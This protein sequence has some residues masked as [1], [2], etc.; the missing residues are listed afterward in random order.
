MEFFL[1]RVAENR[2]Y[3]NTGFIEVILAQKS[4]EVG[5]EAL[6]SNDFSLTDINQ[7]IPG[8]SEGMRGDGITKKCRVLSPLGTGTNYGMSYIP[9]V[10]SLG[11]VA[12]LESNNVKNWTS[13]DGFIWLGGIYGGKTRGKDITLPGDDTDSFNLN[14]EDNEY[15]SYISKS[16]VEDGILDSPYLTE[17][18]F[19]VKLKTSKT[20][21]IKDSTT[22]DVAEKHIHYDTNVCTNELSLRNTRN[23]LR[24]NAYDTNDNRTNIS[25]LT[26]QKDMV[27]LCRITN[28]DHNDDEREEQ[29]QLFDTEKIQ[30]KF[31]N[32]K[33]NVD[34]VLQFDSSQA[35]LYF[36]DPD[37]KKKFS[38]QYDNDAE[39]TTI[40]Q[41]N[42]DKSF[43]RELSF[44]NDNTVLKAD[45]SGKKVT[46]TLDNEG[47]CQIDAT[48]DVTIH[49]GENTTINADKNCTITAKSDCSVTA[50]N[51][52]ISGSQVTLTGGAL[53]A[54]GASNTDTSGPFCAIKVCPITGI[55]HCG[56]SVS[57]T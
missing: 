44:T 5:L 31:I 39:T 35:N 56:S 36:D 55:P 13:D 43:V 3:G 41:S 48:K 54:T 24:F 28:A 16:N 33:T 7:F 47:N 27:Q 49:S 10:N 52:T 2:F 15:I 25:D 8:Y 51:I 14:H 26:M 19:L 1:G 20:N 9:Q 42:T 46:I 29:I 45:Y 32:K 4:E 40:N 17:G 22:D 53:K 30:L 6:L 23:T 57:G 21:G 34:R 50:K 18:M 37:N 12:Q 38:L 11:L